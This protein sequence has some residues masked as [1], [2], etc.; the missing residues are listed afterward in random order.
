MNLLVT[1]KILPQNI[2]SIYIKNNLIFINHSNKIYTISLDSKILPSSQINFPIKKIHLLKN[3]FLFIQ[4]QNTL[5]YKNISESSFKEFSFKFDKIF[6][7]H[8]KIFLLLENEFFYIKKFCKKVFL[9]KID[10]LLDDFYWLKD[11]LF[12]RSKEIIYR[13]NW[14]ERKIYKIDYLSNI[15]INSII[16]NE[17]NFMAYTTDK[18]VII[19]DWFSKKVLVYDL[20]LQNKDVLITDNFIIYFT[21]R[22]KIQCKSTNQII[23]EINLKVKEFYFN[24]KTQ[25]LFLLSEVLFLIKFN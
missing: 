7:V 8:E 17:Y 6:F 3:E 10:F 12:F 19:D 5:F 23:K 2:N 11:V 13:C 21:D 18:N 15:G 9:C 22:L 16:N 14:K 24:K 4:S 1:Y 20:P 25:T